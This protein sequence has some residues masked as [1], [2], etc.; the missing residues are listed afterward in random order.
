MRNVA[1]VQSFFDDN[2]LTGA[3]GQINHGAFL[4]MA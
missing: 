3:P 1:A 2:G 4:C